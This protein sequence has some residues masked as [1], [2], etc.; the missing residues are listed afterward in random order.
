MPRL[1]LI[2]LAVGLT[3]FAIADW[4]AR[5]RTW[6]PGRVN[7]WLWLAV[8]V[9]L[10]IVGPLTWIIVGVVARAEAERNPEPRVEITLRPDDDPSVIS[11]IAD[12]I[13]RRQKRTKHQPPSGQVPPESSE[14][15]NEDE[16]GGDH[17]PPI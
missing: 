12:R 8:I 1:V 13:A 14:S 16:P 15:T 5:S 3:V 2:L 10:P 11:D 7:R 6:T 9:L 4:I 17:T